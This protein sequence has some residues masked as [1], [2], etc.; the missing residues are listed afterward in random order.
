MGC[1]PDCR[2]NL[3]NGAFFSCGNSTGLKPQRGVQKIPVLLTVV[4]RLLSVLVQ[5]FSVQ[6]GQTVR[7]ALPCAVNGIGHFFGNNRIAIFL[8]DLRKRIARAKPNHIVFRFTK[9]RSSGIPTLCQHTRREYRGR[10][11]VPNQGVPWNP[12][13]PKSW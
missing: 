13:R 6:A 5:Q 12:Y 7:L 8:N 9:S 1:R 10:P 3:F 2:S 4:N 11:A